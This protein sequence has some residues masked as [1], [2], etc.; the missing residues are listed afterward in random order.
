MINLF[1][2]NLIY[3]KLMLHYSLG[4]LCYF[5]IGFF[6]GL[7]TFRPD[8]YFSGFAG[9][10]PFGLPTDLCFVPIFTYFEESGE[11]D[12]GC[13][14]NGTLFGLASPIWSCGWNMAPECSC[15]SKCWYADDDCAG[16]FSPHLSMSMLLKFLIGG[17]FEWSSFTAGLSLSNGI[18]AP[19]PSD[20]EASSETWFVVWLQAEIADP[21][22]AGLKKV[23]LW[24]AWV[25]A[26]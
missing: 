15:W 21:V 19:R 24:A 10:C 12:E 16:W 9:C 23:P 5:S 8:P 6:L 1:N 11:R 22:T 26:A 25:V 4:P 2:I 13:F 20:W 7:P 17:S 14:I 3:L 18:P